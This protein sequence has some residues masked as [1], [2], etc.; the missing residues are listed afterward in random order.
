MRTPICAGDKHHSCLPLLLLEVSPL[1]CQ[2]LDALDTIV[3]V[4]KRFATCPALRHGET[5]DGR[6]T[7]RTG[8]KS[9]SRCS[10]APAMATRRTMSSV[11]RASAAGFCGK[12]GR[13]L[14][15][16]DGSLILRHIDHGVFGLQVDGKLGLFLQHRMHLL[17]APHTATPARW[18][19]LPAGGK[20]PHFGKGT[21]CAKCLF[22]SDHASEYAAAGRA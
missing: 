10:H 8:L 12:G 3:H 16:V 2:R 20:R 5:D 11:A 13:A 9:H 6:P 21:P 1:T 17:G 7:P 15:I 22:T 14:T 19:A 18:Y 4:V